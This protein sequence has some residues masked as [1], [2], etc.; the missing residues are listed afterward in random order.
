M[1]FSQGSYDYFAHLIENFEKLLD[2]RRYKARQQM[3][4]CRV[5]MEIDFKTNMKNASFQSIMS[6]RERLHESK[7]RI[8][9]IGKEIYFK[10]DNMDSVNSL[11]EERSTG[12]LETTSTGFEKCNKKQDIDNET[13]EENKSILNAW[14]CDDLEYLAEIVKPETI[15]H[16]NM[17]ELFVPLELND[18]EVKDAIERERKN[19][20]TILRNVSGN[21]KQGSLLDPMFLE[22]SFISKM[23]KNKP[24]LLTDSDESS[25]FLENSSFSADTQEN[26][27][28]G[29]NS[30]KNK[31]SGLADVC[32]DSRNGKNENMLERKTLEE[33]KDSEK[34]GSARM[35]NYEKSDPDTTK[36][37]SKSRK[38]DT[39][40]TIENQ[41]E[42]GNDE[43]EA[44]T[45]IIQQIKQGNEVCRNPLLNA[46]SLNSSADSG[47][48]AAEASLPF[49]EEELWEKVKCVEEEYGKES[50]RGS[51]NNNEK[52]YQ[53]LSWLFDST[54]SNDDFTRDA[55]KRQGGND[56]SEDVR[57]RN[58]P[59]AGA[60]P[61]GF[62]PRSH[63]KYKQFKVEREMRRN[64]QNGILRTE[65]K[66]ITQE[67]IEEQ[68]NSSTEITYSDSEDLWLVTP[69]A[70]Q[71]PYLQSPIIKYLENEGSLKF[72][73][74]ENI[75]MK[76]E[77]D[78]VNGGKKII[79]QQQ[80][81]EKKKERRSK[82]PIK[83]HLKK[84]N[85]QKTERSME[86]GD[87][88]K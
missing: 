78:A 72:T 39:D 40:I 80:G 69:F 32:S 38:V 64:E 54:G 23:K 83:I 19:E 27:M 76:M 2:E 1:D 62:S 31:R 36:H 34:E 70:S 11:D 63:S 71:S 25:S 48:N 51:V 44:A 66:M 67:P 5:E 9:N 15:I 49:N 21:K 75:N 43:I 50:I 20:T 3:L 35:V 24:S 55:K 85:L 47:E 26:D 13:K 42:K 53:K 6:L 60:T 82:I 45:A 7:K 79:H 61:F 41:Y 74:G 29:C 37:S 17:E 84:K 4:K 57:K 8:K 87:K 86:E 88:T 33:T 12:K 18:W 68:P 28:D 58:I 81:Y 73:Y 46:S 56:Q 59:V 14:K 16:E 65:S 10:I 52:N 30:M 22:K 77:K